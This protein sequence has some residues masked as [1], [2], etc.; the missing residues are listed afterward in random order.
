VSSGEKGPISRE[1]RAQTSGDIEVS[2]NIDESIVDAD[3][4]SGDEAW[5]AWFTWW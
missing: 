5:S 2:G 1:R 3:S 4:V